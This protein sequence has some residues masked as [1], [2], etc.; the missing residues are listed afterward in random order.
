MATSSRQN[1]R[2]RQYVR[3]GNVAVMFQTRSQLMLCSYRSRNN[4]YSDVF[5]VFLSPSGKI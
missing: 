1:S 4:G 5:V 2:E 3:V